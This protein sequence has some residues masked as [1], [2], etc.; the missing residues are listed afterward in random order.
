[1]ASHDH[2]DK[3]ELTVLLMAGYFFLPA[4]CLAAMACCF[5][6]AALLA[7][8]CFCEDFFWLDFGDLSPITLLFYRG[9]TLLRHVS[10]SEGKYTV[11]G[12]LVIVNTITHLFPACCRFVLRYNPHPFENCNRIPRRLN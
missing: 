5:F 2:F 4:V 3:E 6:W 11:D 10:F 9:L 12:G 8:E 7:F 1:V